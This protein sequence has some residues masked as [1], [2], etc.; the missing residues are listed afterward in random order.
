MQLSPGQ[1]PLKTRV[2]ES[3]L[4]AGDVLSPQSGNP[5]HYFQ[6]GFLLVL[7]F[8]VPALNTNIW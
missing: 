8:L 2:S 3:V 7:H 6:A 5:N 4:Q 1:V